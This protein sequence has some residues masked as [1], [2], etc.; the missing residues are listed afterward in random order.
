MSSRATCGLYVAKLRVVSPSYLCVAD[1]QLASIG[2]WQPPQDVIHDEW[3]AKHAI[4]ESLCARLFAATPGP[5]A[6]DL[7]SVPSFD[8]SLARA[9]RGLKSGLAGSTV[10][11]PSAP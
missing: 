6:K 10:S 11:L 5:Q 8:I 4:W 3:Q 9:A 7:P 1:F 2:K